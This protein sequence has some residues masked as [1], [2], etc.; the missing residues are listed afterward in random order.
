VIAWTPRN[1]RRGRRAFHALWLGQSISQ[2][3][4]QISVVVLPLVAAV[5]LHASPFEVGLLAALETAPYLLIALP[6]GVIADRA[7][8]RRLLILTDLGR[9]LA[10]LLVPLAFAVNM[11]SLPILFV[12]ALVTGTLSVFFDVA[13]QSYLP[14]LVPT[15]QLV[16]GNQKL[17]L[18]NAGAHVAGPALAGI[19]LAA[20]GASVAV[21]MDA[22]SFLVSALVVTLSPNAARPQAAPRARS[23]LS[24]S[25]WSGVRLVLRDRSLR[26]LAGSTATFN[27]ASSAIL[28]VFVVFATRELSVNP[29]VFGLLYGLGNVGF[30]LGAAVVGTAS[31]LIGT[32]RTVFLAAALGTAATLMM[33]LAVG[34]LA[35]LMLF[36]GRFVGAFAA[37]CFNVNTYSI[38]QARTPDD[39]LGRV[40]ATFK[41]LDW[42]T[43]PIGA[44]IGG[45]IGTLFG[46]RPALVFAAFMGVLSVLWLVRSPVRKMA[47]LTRVSLLDVVETAGPLPE[48]MSVSPGGPL[49]TR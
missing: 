35:V 5:T 28:A 7:D 25:M 13:Y 19:V 9:A 17:E 27:L 12:V 22:I 39:V 29:A 6:A 44:L 46:V 49:I 24:G 31:R 42:G 40:N 2:L 15:D 3:G 34:E 36:G 33:P 20:V 8:R 4:S 47:R 45:T 26:D 48:R 14:R 32:G 1:R 23:A 21:L 16:D 30:V 11:L 10:L 41:L 43:L 38:R 18:S 37:A